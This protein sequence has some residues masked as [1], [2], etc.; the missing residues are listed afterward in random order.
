MPSDTSYWRL[1]PTIENTASSEDKTTLISSSHRKSFPDGD[2]PPIQT[3][4]K[5]SL[6][7]RTKYEKFGSNDITS[8]DS[9]SEFMAYDSSTIKKNNFKQIVASNI[10]EK[11]QAVCKSKNQVK[12]P[13]V[14][15]LAKVRS[16]KVS[17]NQSKVQ[18]VD[19]NQ[20][21]EPKGSDNDSIGSASDLRTEDDFF[22]EDLRKTD[23]MKL[24]RKKFDDAVSESVKTCGSS[25]YH[26]E[27]ES[28][29]TNEDNASRVV[30]RVRMRKK[31]RL[32]DSTNTIIDQNQLSPSSAEFLHQYGDRPL[33]LDDELE[34]E[35]NSSDNTDVKEDESPEELDVFAMAPFKMPLSKPRKPKT[36]K[37]PNIYS[38]ESTKPVPV[39][40]TDKQKSAEIWTSTPKKPTN[41]E[42]SSTFFNT[43]LAN[44]PPPSAV[45]VCDAP[46]AINCSDPAPKLDRQGVESNS[47]YGKV[48]VTASQPT[49]F[50]SV[51]IFGSVPFP[52]VIEK[53]VQKLEQMRSTKTDDT[54]T[55]LTVINVNSE[56]P[57]RKVHHINTL[58]SLVT[59]NQSIV[60]DKTLDLTPNTAS[61]SSR[62]FIN[63]SNP[64][65]DHIL[66]IADNEFVSNPNSY[67]QYDEEEEVLATSN[68][69][70]KEKLSKYSKDKVKDSS[71]ISTSSV[72]LPT[73]IASKVKG[74]PLNYKKVSYKPSKKD[75]EHPYQ[76]GFSNMSFED[77]PSD[78]E[79]DLSNDDN[80]STCKITPFEVMRNDKIMVEV[81]KKFSSLKRKP[82]LFS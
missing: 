60:I 59:V 75:A 49:Q 76:N 46:Q 9:D 48:T 33:L 8:D 19:N 17:A 22:D 4:G 58:Q 11:F 12:V 1:S 43:Y 32:N 37:N 31:D 56:L 71:S 69:S 29:T 2:S 30:V 70:K 74:N 57:Q 82:N 73:M 66:P 24:N 27:C 77:F 51:D 38:S 40:M 23:V 45:N 28:V 3:F 50:S 79:L 47:S 52:Q 55:N 5:I 6:E 16:S 10:H 72:R 62:K 36:S 81:E 34:L 14:R 13:I 61:S 18:A 80:V 63:F 15:K 7:D 21:N 20:A 25:A 53:S 67:D 65:P 64:P 68:K 41:T 54:K 44:I 78:H 35:Y 26:A 39:Q 42:D